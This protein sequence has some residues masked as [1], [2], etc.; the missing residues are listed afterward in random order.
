MAD[1]LNPLFDPS[2]DNQVIPEE[3]QQML[4]KPLAGGQL[5]QD[6]QAFI[7]QIMSLVEDGT[8]KLHEP[9]SLLN[10]TVYEGLPL[11][12]KAK[13]D[14]SAM[15]MLGK[16]RDIVDLEHVTMDTLY[17]EK[18][19]VAALRWQKERVETEQGDIFII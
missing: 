14:Q 9:S 11:E 3:T 19:L 18:N 1:D 17:Q 8:I 16:I 4:N 5:S 6:E 12:I 10:A 13:A 15:L 7:D 2:T